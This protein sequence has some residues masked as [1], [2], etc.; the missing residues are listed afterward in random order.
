MLYKL[1]LFPISRKCHK[2]RAVSEQQLH[3]FFQRTGDMCYVGSS[4][5]VHKI[6]CTK[7]CQYNVA[8]FPSTLQLLQP[9]RRRQ[10]MYV[11]SKHVT[12]SSSGNG[13]IAQVEWR[14]RKGTKNRLL[15]PQKLIFPATSDT[16]HS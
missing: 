12:A 10:K 14:R 7:C 6:R 2:A 5:Q 13:R 16:T 9:G 4:W 15:L 1:H 11:Q 8:V 3:A